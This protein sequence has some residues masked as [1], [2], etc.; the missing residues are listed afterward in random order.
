MKF[1]IYTEHPLYKNSPNYNLQ[2][3]E[4]TRPHIM[5]FSLVLDVL[6]EIHALYALKC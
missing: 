1:F 5:T 3:P 4:K 2:L 6:D